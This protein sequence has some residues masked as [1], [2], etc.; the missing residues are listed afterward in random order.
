MVREFE[1]VLA[2]PPLELPLSLEPQAA[3]PNARA[4]TRQP[5]AASPRARKSPSSRTHSETRQHREPARRTTPPAGTASV[6]AGRVVP[7]RRQEEARPGRYR[8]VMRTIS[9]TR[10]MTTVTRKASIALAPMAQSTI[11]MMNPAVVAR[12]KPMAPRT[13]AEGRPESRHERPHGVGRR[14][15]VGRLHGG[16]DEAAADDDP[17]RAGGRALGRLL[18][19]RDPE[20]ER[21]GDAGVGAR[22]GDDVRERVGQ[23]GALAGRPR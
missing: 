11:Q 10:T 9:S 7:G 22:A 14:P 6:A 1:P 8:S 4:V 16:A 17:V 23:R 15:R 5:E 21:D 12:T 2:E 13:L 20:P 18:G 19:R 3:T